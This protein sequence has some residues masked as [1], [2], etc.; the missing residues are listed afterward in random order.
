M[1]YKDLLTETKMPEYYSDI[2]Q[3]LPTMIIE[4]MNNA[5]NK[6]IDE[7]EVKNVIWALHPDKSP[8]PYGFS[9]SFYRTYCDL[10]KKIF[11]NWYNGPKGRRKLG[12]T[13]ISTFLSLIPKE[14]HPSSFSRFRPISL[15][16][17]SYKI[18]TKILAMSFK[19]HLHSLILENQGGFISQRLINDT[20]LLVKEAI[21]SRKLRKEKGFILKLDLANAFDRVRHSFLL[22]VLQKMGF[23]PNFLSLINSC[24]SGPWIS[25]LINGRLAPS[26]QSSQGLR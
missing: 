9:I 17:S 8:G 22:V 23:D 12:A 2:L 18:I 21:H 15:C 25:P 3:H 14:N 4:D 7:E 13:P 11:S 1:H 10:I 20:I 16:N 19:P 5:F 24:I 26:F 6:E